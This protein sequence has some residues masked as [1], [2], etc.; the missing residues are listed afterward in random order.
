MS[1]EFE[2]NFYIQEKFIYILGPS[3][4]EKLFDSQMHFMK[5]I[6]LNWAWALCQKRRLTY[7]SH[8]PLP[9]LG[10]NDNNVWLL[11]ITKTTLNKKRGIDIYK[12]KVEYDHWHL[13]QIVVQL[14]IFNFSYTRSISFVF[15]SNS[16]RAPAVWY[17]WA[18]RGSCSRVPKLFI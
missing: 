15:V 14:E 13:V 6:L 10:V 11:H 5:V 18:N 4:E 9:K 16:V 12:G 2:H 1:F 8:G 17:F 3:F 7:F